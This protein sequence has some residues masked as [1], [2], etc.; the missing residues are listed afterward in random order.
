MKVSTSAQLI[1]PEKIAVKRTDLRQQ[2]SEILSKA[3]GTTV[4]VVAS[5]GQH[6]DEK[7]ILSKRYFDELVANVESLAETL[8]ILA[9]R[10]LFD[11]IMTASETLEDDLKRGKLHSFEEAFEEP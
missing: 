3:R 4:V 10:N 7:C 11:Q 6:A 8:E 1:R 9:D 5:A 2:Q